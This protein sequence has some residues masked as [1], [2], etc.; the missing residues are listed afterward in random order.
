MRNRGGRR[1][2]FAQVTLFAVWK[3]RSRSHERRG[4]R[5]D[6]GDDGVHRSSRSSA[7]T[8]HKERKRSERKRK[9]DGE[10]DDGEDESKDNGETSSAPG[11]DSQQRPEVAQ[12]AAQP[13]PGG[14]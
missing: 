10:E 14:E 3:S 6:Y 13:A 4:R 8:S 9:R 1:T 5:D 2:S 11:D 12:P 7:K